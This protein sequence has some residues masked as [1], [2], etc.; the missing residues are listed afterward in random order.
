MARDLSREQAR[1][2]RTLDRALAESGSGTPRRFALVR[3]LERYPLSLG[4]LF[5]GRSP[6]C[7]L[8][9]DD[10]MVSRRHAKL[11]VSENAVFV[12]DLGS[13]NGVRVDGVQVKARTLLAPGSELQVANVLFKLTEDDARAAPRSE[14][15]DTRDA[16]PEAESTTRRADAFRLM[17]G[18]VDKALLLGKPDDAERLIGTLMA[19]VLS[20][21][22]ARRDV[23]AA[24]AESASVTALRLASVTGKR[25]WAEYPLRLHLALGTAPPRAVVD[26]LFDLV[27][28]VGRIDVALLESVIEA[29]EAARQLGPSDKFTLQR[30]HNLARMLRT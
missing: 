16:A 23:P 25:H 6:E 19:D 14:R 15:V 1:T 12:E 9:V 4:E 10:S 3:G 30:L 21:A 28:R 8:V 5:I 26:D 17:L 22:Q 24:V 18:V 7:E 27:R 13:V 29:L 20:D 2:L 11:V